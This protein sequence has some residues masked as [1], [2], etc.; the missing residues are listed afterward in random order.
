M[1]NTLFLLHA[2]QVYCWSWKGMKYLTMISISWCTLIIFLYRRIYDT[3]QLLEQ[4]NTSEWKSSPGATKL[5]SVN[6][7][8]GDK[9]TLIRCLL[10]PYQNVHNH[11]RIGKYSHL[12]GTFWL[13]INP[14]DPTGYSGFCSIDLY[15][16]TDCY[17]DPST[18]WIL[19]CTGMRLRGNISWQRHRETW[20]HKFTACVLNKCRQHI[21]RR[22]LP[23]HT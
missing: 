12:I 8:Y 11:T 14:D 1:C 5:Q 20:N 22:Y 4:K 18:Q 7:T 16:G 13:K 6:C 2:E 17:G 21:M 19:W 23:H 3:Y 10:A 15:N 9:C